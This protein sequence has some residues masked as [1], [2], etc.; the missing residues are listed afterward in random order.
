MPDLPA[1]SP[2]PRAR[3]RG[4]RRAGG[5]LAA[6]TLA[7]R[8]CAPTCS[9]TAAPTCRG[10]RPALA[11]STASVLDPDNNYCFGEGGAGTFSDGKLYTRPRG[12]GPS[13]I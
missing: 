3:G 2:G 4:G 9:S 10:R 6:W 8:A 11:R 13:R 12:G 7:G 1:P 5:L